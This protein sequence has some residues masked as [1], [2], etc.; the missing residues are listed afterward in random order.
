MEF[1]DPAWEDLQVLLAALEH[2]SLSAA[3]ASLGVGQSTV[4]RRL[5][6]LEQRLGARLLDRTPEG[7]RAT[8]LAA[9]I[10]PHAALIAEQMSDIQRL[11]V[12]E[13]VGVRGRVRLALPD[14]MA[15]AWIVPRI[16]PLLEEYPELEVDLITGLE[17]VDLVRR[18]AD[19]A[20]RFVA[21][22]HPELLVRRVAKLQLRA[23][24]H[25][26]L[27]GESLEDLRVVELWDPAGNYL[28]TQ[29][30]RRHAPHAQRMRVTNWNALFSAVI[31]RL[32]AG[33]LSPAVAEPAGLVPVRG[34]P[35]VGHRDLL[36]VY[37][38]ALRDVPRV[39]V[40]RDW[41]LA[42]APRVGPRRRRR[43]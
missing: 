42:N 26:D 1:E 38:P 17:V 32:G 34:V 22:T 6:R 11:V 37:H 19:L 9:R 3:A 23:F 16:A 41:L 4:S 24:V 30:L 43:S 10:A 33:V 13:T 14:G 25:P 7:S 39:A 2:G 18:E 20:L 35:K 29:W 12:N 15:S 21:P 5:A 40:V 36:L 8:E 28:E 31:N 27:A